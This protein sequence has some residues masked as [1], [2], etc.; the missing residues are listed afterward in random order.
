MSV[1]P[2]RLFG[3]S[4]SFYR[5]TSYGAAVEGAPCIVR[6]FPVRGQ[7]SRSYLLDFQ[8]KV[9]KKTMVHHTGSFEISFFKTKEEALTAACVNRV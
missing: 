9:S 5:G 1:A 4:T 8:M 2:E 7:T 6:G 3:V